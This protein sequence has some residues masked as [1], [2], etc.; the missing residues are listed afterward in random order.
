[1]RAF[2]GGPLVD[3]PKP[4]SDIVPTIPRAL[5]AVLE[6]AMAED[7]EDRYASATEMRAAIADAIAP[8]ERADARRVWAW[9]SEL[10]KHA[11]EREEE[12]RGVPTITVPTVR[13]AQPSEA[14]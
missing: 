7:K 6:R 8:M 11:A 12:A 3:R 10:V 9:V 5:D 2:P 14:E 1:V 4:A 13:A